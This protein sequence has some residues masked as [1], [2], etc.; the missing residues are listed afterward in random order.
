MTGIERGPHAPK[1]FAYL[2]V[3]RGL[4]S[5]FFALRV[6]GVWGIAGFM[7]L[8]LRVEGFRR[9]GLSDLAKQEY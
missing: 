6:W 8:M 9:K 3:T 5:V 1:P 2:V 7:R 4:T